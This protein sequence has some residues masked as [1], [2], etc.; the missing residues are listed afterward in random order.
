MIKTV[1]QT[2]TSSINVDDFAQS[3]ADKFTASAKSRPSRS[4]PACGE[5][6]GKEKGKK[7]GFRIIS[8]KGCGTLY[9]STLP[10]AVSALDY[11]DYY[12]ERNL[13][14]PDFIRRRTDEIVAAFSPY[15][16][17]NRLLEVGFGEGSL[18]RAA[19]RA[20]W[21][22]EG[23]EVSRTA[24]EHVRAEGL[25][26]F[27]GELASA[28]YPDASFDVVIASEVLEHVSDPEA[29]LKEVARVL[30][31]G[32][33]FWATT[34][35]A[36]GLSSRLLGMRWSVTDP[37]EHLHLF[38]PRGVTAL[39]KSAGFSAVRV[40]T[41]GVNPY[42]IWKAL[43]KHVSPNGDHE[44]CD[45]VETGYLLNEA[46]TKSDLHRALKNLVNGLLRMSHLGDSLKIWAER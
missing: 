2:S 31:K 1:A 16:R 4:C 15:R 44:G 45:R 12:T 30:G 46:L 19:V 41:H 42:E 25:K 6:L 8:C 23:V 9:V 38:S 33:L 35:N 13:S 36:L 10:E 21:D 22:A 26:A 5:S 7:Q 40:M 18:L 39:L 11:D 20:G 14:V 28:S 32:G 29:M 3:A 43:R 17:T 34:P 24:V 37:P 27:C